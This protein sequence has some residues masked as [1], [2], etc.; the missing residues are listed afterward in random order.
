MAP[1]QPINVFTAVVT[2]NTAISCANPEEVLI[3]VT[4]DGVPGNT[5]TYE[6]LPVGN[7]LGSMTSNPTNITATFELTQPGS[8]TFRITDTVTGCYFDTTPYDIAPYDLIDVVATPT[9]PA[10]CFGDT[11]GALE[12][13]VTGYTGTYSYQIFDGANNPIGSLVN[14]DTSVNPRPITG[15]SG[16]NYYVRVTQTANPLCVEDSNVITI[17]SP[18]MALSATPI[19]VANVTCANNLGE[20]EVSPT[21]GFAPY[22]IQLTNTTTSQV[23][24]VSNVVSFVFQD[25]SAGLFDVEIV[26]GAGCTINEPITLTQ[27]TPITADINATPTNLVCFGDTNATVTAQNVLNGRGVY[28]Y[29]LN[30]YDPTGTTIVSTSGGQASQAFNNLGAGIYSITVSD[31][32]SCDVETI[33][34]TISEPVEVMANLIQVSQM[35]CT[36][37]ADIQLSAVGGTAPYQYSLDGVVYSNMSG[38]NTHTFTVPAGAYQ[39]YVRDAF[40]CEAMISNQVTVDP[41]I[42]LDMVIDDS[43]ATINCT[44][45]ASAIIRATAVGGLG[46]YSYELFADAGLTSSVAGPQPT[47]EFSGLVAGQY[48]VHVTSMDCDATSLAIDIIDP[49]PLQIDRQESTDVTCSGLEDGTI[50]VEVSGGTGEIFYAITPNLDQ[51]DTVGTF[52]DL[53]PGIY[54]VIAQD[55][56]GCFETFQFEIIQP[57]SLQAQ[58]INVMHEVCFNSADGSFELDITGGTA[59]YFTSLNS[60]ADADYVQDQI[61]FQNLAAGTQVVFVRD[62]QGCET[63]VFVEINPGV[64]L[65]A[66][67]DPIYECDG[68]LPTNRLDIEFEDQTVIG[69]VMYAIDSTDPA[70]L[71]LTSDF[72]NIAPG[73]HYLTIAHSNGC[74]N[75]IDFT[76]TGFE[77]LTLVLENSNINEITATAQ[78]GLEDYT[79][80]FG[81]VNNGTDN[82]YIINRTDTYP[83]TVVDQNGCEVT[84]EIFMEFIDIE[85]PDF[86]TPD[87]DNMNDTWLP[88]NLEAFPNVLMIIFDRY[89]R[90]LYRMGYGDSGWNGIYNN[91]ELP[92]G[93]YWYII[94]LQGENDDRELVGHFT[95]YRQ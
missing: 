84:M 78:G 9:A 60:N 75:T 87:G 52:T 37:Q 13:N 68:N 28:Q 83:V 8:Y 46:N 82:T 81:D 18:D 63:N 1:I 86:F 23:Y 67:V 22:D 20:I 29:Q 25:L 49:T 26:D 65:A 57:Q 74:I 59:P 39:Y 51:F 4:D 85:V 80:Y 92:T 95:L 76:I 41:I 6:L 45:E 53:A 19:E 5:Y 43:A 27:P 50:T 72:T 17:A 79:F 12:I 89:G 3:T 94:K 58:A 38:G 77:P 21:G 7:P 40:G 88:D 61:L 32:W 31:G 66:L 16:G 11:N 14:T 34:V 48:F 30:V 71:Q 44:G 42:P 24:N 70:D 91:S 54:D 64:N 73:D 15:L 62:A 2:Q 33:Q 56:N 35:T 93:D 36:S 47:G 69:E 55:R 90:E 10:I